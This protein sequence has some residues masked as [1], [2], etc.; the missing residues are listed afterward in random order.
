LFSLLLSILEICNKEEKAALARGG[1][2]HKDE[3]GDRV[4]RVRS[5]TYENLVK[6]GESILDD[7]DD[8]ISRMIDK[9][10]KERKKAK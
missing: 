9:E 8:I 1:S 3:R 6:L 10:F 7:F 4:I 5:S 2:Y